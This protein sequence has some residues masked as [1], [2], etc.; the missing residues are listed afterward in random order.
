MIRGHDFGDGSKRRPFSIERMASVAPTVR[1]DFYVAPRP[2]QC[3]MEGAKCQNESAFIDVYSRQ[4]YGI[5][6]LGHGIGE[7][8]DAGAS[9]IMPST[10]AELAACAAR[11]SRCTR[12]MFIKMR[13]ENLP[14][15]MVESALP[16][17]HA[18]PFVV[19]E[20]GVPTPDDDASDHDLW[21]GS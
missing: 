19:Q 5:T 2:Q 18:S 13:A 12:A 10:L 21:A 14:T 4:G 9:Q 11:G 1:L 20:P 17:L 8:T 6:T 7:V 3:I 16:Q 15:K